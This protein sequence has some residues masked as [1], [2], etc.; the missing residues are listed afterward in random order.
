M[1]KGLVTH[2]G[3]GQQNGLWSRVRRGSRSS[4]GPW[5]L[6]R[7]PTTHD[8]PF[9]HSAGQLSGQHVGS[10]SAQSCPTPSL[11]QVRV[12]RALGD[13][14]PAPSTPSQLLP[15]EPNCKGMDEMRPVTERTHPT[16]AVPD[17]NPGERSLG[18][19]QTVPRSCW[20][21][22]RRVLRPSG[23][24][25]CLTPDTGVSSPTLRGWLGHPGAPVS[26]GSCFPAR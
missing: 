25:A 15:G 14:H 26:S 22:Q 7:W 2:D 4:P 8:G 10:P 5:P 13:S 16:R 1:K 18:R 11:P 20:L 23:D 3:C 21:S 24:R 9:S 19:P 12:P 17:V 6:P